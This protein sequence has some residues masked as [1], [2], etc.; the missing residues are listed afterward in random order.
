MGWIY[1]ASLVAESKSHY[2]SIVAIAIFTMIVMLSVTLARGFIRFKFFRTLDVD[3][4]LIIV[5]MVQL[6]VSR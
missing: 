1:N 3:D 2:A 5:A 4:G 6:H